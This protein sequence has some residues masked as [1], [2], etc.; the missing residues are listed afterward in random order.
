MMRVLDGVAQGVVGVVGG[1][2]ADEHVRQLLQPQQRLA[3]DGPVPAV[4][5]EDP[6]LSFEDVQRRTA[7]SA[8]L[9]CRGRAPRCRAASRARC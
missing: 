2:R 7:Q 8:A 1:V 5:V 3:F 4:G 9:Q 6:F